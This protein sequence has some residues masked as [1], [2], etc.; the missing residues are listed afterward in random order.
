MNTSSSHSIISLI[1]FLQKSIDSSWES[2]SHLP[3]TEKFLKRIQNNLNWYLEVIYIVLEDKDTSNEIKEKFFG[4]INKLLYYLI[5][6]I[7]GLCEGT[8]EKIPFLVGV[9]VRL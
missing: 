2:S 1:S 3:E 4:D 7:K 9:I 8:T 5:P 6:P